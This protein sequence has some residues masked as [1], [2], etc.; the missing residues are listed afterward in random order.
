MAE[1]NYTGTIQLQV[2]D[3]P[4]FRML[5]INRYHD[6]GESVTIKFCPR[7]NFQISVHDAKNPRLTFSS[8]VELFIKSDLWFSVIDGFVTTQSTHF[9]YWC[10]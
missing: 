2:N 4:P 7:L 3:P 6:F 9:L 8:V 10:F 5:R 1:K